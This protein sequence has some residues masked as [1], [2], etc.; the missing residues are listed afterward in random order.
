MQ[1]FVMGELEACGVDQE[2][3]QKENFSYQTLQKRQGVDDAKA[4]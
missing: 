4:S 3:V 1:D 2:S